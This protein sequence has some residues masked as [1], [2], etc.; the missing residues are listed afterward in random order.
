MHF[1]FTC[2]RPIVD[3]SSSRIVCGIELSRALMNEVSL[4][5][6]S[7]WSQYV[8]VAG[9]LSG[10]RC[11]TIGRGLLL[12]RLSISYGRPGYIPDT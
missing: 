12:G 8:L 10:Q 2:I 5:C 9:L 3:I 6:A 1:I 4:V 7:L 11:T